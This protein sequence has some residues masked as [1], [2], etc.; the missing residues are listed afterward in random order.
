M[1][2]LEIFEK[3]NLV[4]PIEQRHFF[5]YFNDSVDE[6]IATFGYFVLDS[7]GEY[8][9][10]KDLSDSVAVLP[11]YCAAIVDSIIFLAGSGQDEMRKSEFLRKAKAAY[12]KYWN[13][14]A[15]GKRVKRMR[16]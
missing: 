4:I 15:K 16:W 7:E 13:D 5:N 1:T 14:H 2:L 6:L 9:P 10:P 8:T 12:L 3:V 11:L